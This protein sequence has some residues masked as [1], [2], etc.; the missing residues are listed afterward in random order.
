MKRIL[1]SAILFKT[2]PMEKES[3]HFRRLKL[4]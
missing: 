2:L 3:T 1:N 4:V